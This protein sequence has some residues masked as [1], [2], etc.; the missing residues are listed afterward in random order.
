MNARTKQKGQKMTSN[1]E[2]KHSP[3]P[4]RVGKTYMDE[5][6]TLCV[7]D[8]DGVEIYVI[9][10]EAGQRCLNDAAYIVDAVNSHERLVAE[11]A[12]LRKVL[13]RISEECSLDYWQIECR[14]RKA[15]G[16]EAAN[17]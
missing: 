15:L 6:R 10:S 14:A 7:E 16:E 12:R 9:G 13:E 4:W 2:T 5:P 17:D 1:I 11:N 3:T 8:A